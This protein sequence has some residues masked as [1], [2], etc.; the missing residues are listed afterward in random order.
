MSNMTFTPAQQDA[1]FAKP[2]NLL[3]SAAAGS[4]KTAVLT[5]RVIELLT[6]EQPVMAD[7]LVIVTF[8]VAAAAQMRERIQDK[9]SA[10]LE[11]HPENILLQTQQTL[12]SKAK[13]CTIHSLCSELIKDHTE[14]LNLSFRCRLAD[15]NEMK[16]LEQEVLEEY[17]ESCYDSEEKDFLSLARYFSGK[18]D[19]RLSNILLGIYHWMR[20]YSFPFHRLELFLKQYLDD[21][22]FLDS[23]WGKPVLAYVEKSLS[24][25]ERYLSSALE[26]AS[27]Q[28]E[29]M[30]KYSPALELDLDAVRRAEKALRHGEWDRV[31]GIVKTH[32]K[33]RFSPIRGFEDKSFLDRIKAL[34]NEGMELF[35]TLG[36]KYL[37]TEEE[38]QSDREYLG[39]YIKMLFSYVEGFYRRL[40]EEK[41]EQ[42]LIDF[43]DLEHLAL[44]LLVRRE[45]DYCYKTDT[46]RELS[47]TEILV[48]ECQDINQ[49]QNLIF[50][51]LSDGE[52]KVSLDGDDLFESSRNLFLVGDVKQSIYRFRNAMPSLFIRRKKLFPPYDREHPEKKQTAR[53]V[54]QNNFRSRREVTDSVN[55]IFSAVMSEQL[56]DVDYTEEEYLIPSAVYPAHD[57]GMTQLHLLELPQKEERSVRPG[58]G[59]DEKTLAEAR[60]AAELIEHMVASGFP[61]TENGKLRA[62]TYRDFC[63][64]LRSKK[65]KADCYVKELTQKGI[66]CFSDSSSG[67]FDSSEVS[68]MLHLLRVIDNPLLDIPLFSV[69]ISPMF[70]FTPDEITA[71]RLEDKRSPFYL[72]LVKSAQDGNE[73]ARYFLNVLGALREQAAVLSSDRLIQRIYDQTGFLFVVEA[74]ASGEQK[75]ANLRLLL[76]Y[77]RSY[78]EIGYRGLSGFLRFID[79]AAERGED[80][81]CANTVSEKADVVRIMS[82]HSSKGLEFPIC[83]V[84]DLGKK[85]NLQELTQSFLLHENYGFGMTVRKTEELKEYSNLPLEAIR[86]AVRQDTLS[87]EMRILYVALTRAKEKLI[88]L[89]SGQDI[90][91]LLESSAGENGDTSYLS[92]ILH[93]VA[94]EHGFGKLLN[95]E[96]KPVVLGRIQCIRAP[97]IPEGE[98]EQEVISF[99]ALP[100]EKI[101]K[102]LEKSLHFEY[103][104]K[105]L[106]ELPAKVTATQLAQKELL[107]TS[108]E[109]PE[110]SLS[111]EGDEMTGARRG[112]VLHS[113][114]Q[115]A[116][117]HRAKHD[118]DGEVSR[119]VEKGFLTVKEGSLLNRKKIRSFLSSPLFTRMEQAQ[120][121]YREYQFIYEI[122]AGRVDP[123]LKDDFRQE[124][125]LLQGIADAVLEEKDGIVIV[126]YKTDR[127]S[128]EDDFIEKYSGQLN[129]Y[130]DALGDYFGKPVKD[131]LIY[132]LHLE[133]EIP[134]PPTK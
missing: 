108:G 47:Y 65:G 91:R 87:E 72:A 69:L 120:R 73:K 37:L 68:V 78:E 106:S 12:L 105:E 129:I 77:A 21:G 115:Y 19:R 39:K 26:L 20:S 34:R 51:A 128:Q 92:W 10:L 93:A 85:F 90:D 38:F 102:S 3:V 124:K 52:D 14:Q 25:C 123:D 116:D 1:I 29:V 101:V 107:E 134:V 66:P 36:K 16:L 59:M 5:Q 103:P 31:C 9:L 23:I 98:R 35:E 55:Q 50:W 53:I 13:I 41:R 113:F 54:L 48:D 118:L 62:C 28:E 95:K 131:C 22:P 133:R 104:Y 43:N 81:N 121:L 109:L 126:D 40:E 30:K 49:V 132:S 63:I 46:A 99:T 76:S 130:R 111:E 117:Y 84:A 4:G 57:R 42:N 18:D 96:E 24:N 8:T 79:R 33:K 58:K 44:S 125:V 80:F 74:M 61:V 6:G 112:T 32:E 45:G 122:D 60:Y 2:G 100:D 83:I 56:G 67:Y 15:E 82:I 64:L 86:L 97:F 11:E 7:R 127:M 70:G 110:L 71:V 88:L 119:L 17:I 94:K 27:S 89:G 75:K 114:M